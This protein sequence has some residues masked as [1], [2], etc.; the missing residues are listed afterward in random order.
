MHVASSASI[1]SAAA[2]W[3]AA[4]RAGYGPGEKRS[5]YFGQGL[6]GALEIGRPLGVGELVAEVDIDPWQKMVA[7][8]IEAS[9]FHQNFYD[10]MFSEEVNRELLDIVTSVVTG[11]RT[12]EEAADAL[13]TA[14]EFSH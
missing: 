1:A 14:W 12:A 4:P 10:V 5:V 3:F 8:T 13:Q 6:V 11:D 9:A 2:A 7:Q